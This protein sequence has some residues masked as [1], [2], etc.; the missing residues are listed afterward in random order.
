MMHPS[1]YRGRKQL[2]TGPIYREV[3][4]EE[5]RISSKKER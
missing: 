3:G 4:A 1:V 5:V 2:E